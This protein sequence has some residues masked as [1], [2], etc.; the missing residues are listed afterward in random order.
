MNTGIIKSHKPMTVSEMVNRSRDIDKKTSLNGP[1]KPGNKIIFGFPVKVNGMKAIGTVTDIT[2]IEN[3]RI[4]TVL[5]NGEL[6][7]Y[8]LDDVRFLGLNKERDLV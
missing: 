1:T 3:V 6:I 4:I 8:S 7:D 2:R 5:I